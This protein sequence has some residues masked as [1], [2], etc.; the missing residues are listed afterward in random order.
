VLNGRFV[1][2]LA[3]GNMAT[4]WEDLEEVWELV[5]QSAKKT[6]AAP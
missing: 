6:V 1:L 3:I 2:R 4:R 5:R